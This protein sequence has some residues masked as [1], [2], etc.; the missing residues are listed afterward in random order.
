[1]PPGRHH[2]IRHATRHNTKTGESPARVSH[3][4][5][6]NRLIYGLES[7]ARRTDDVES[8]LVALHVAREAIH[9]FFHGCDRVL[10]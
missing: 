3:A 7:L 8:A 1:M 5:A 4:G 9:I 10:V 2:L 6:E